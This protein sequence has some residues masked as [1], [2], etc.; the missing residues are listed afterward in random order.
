MLARNSDRLSICVNVCVCI[1][2]YIFLKGERNHRDVE[3]SE[4]RTSL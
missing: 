4:V 1:C 2:V 3:L